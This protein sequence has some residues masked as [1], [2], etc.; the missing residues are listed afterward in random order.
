MPGIPLFLCRFPKEHL[1]IYIPLAYGDAEYMQTVSQA[2][3][4]RFG[5]EQVTI[6]R[7]S[8]PYEKYC[9]FI[10]NCIDVAILDAPQQSGLGNIFLLLQLGK[11]VFLHDDGLNKKIC[12]E[13]GFHTFNSSLIHSSNLSLEEI[14]NLDANIRETNISR[15]TQYMDPFVAKKQWDD[16]F[17]LA[18]IQ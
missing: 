1:H 11:K 16:V 5:T 9:E 17:K 6:L 18:E 10:A 15:A 7:E 4:H 14:A 13:A 2:A 3:F 12:D 8:L